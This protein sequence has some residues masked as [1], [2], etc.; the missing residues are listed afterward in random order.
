MT[1]RDTV[2]LSP[3]ASAASEF[4]ALA[5]MTDRRDTAIVLDVLARYE[6]TADWLAGVCNIDKGHLSR[7]LNGQ[8]TMP[9]AVTTA[10]YV[11][12]RDAKLRDFLLG[13]PDPES[14]ITA[15]GELAVA[16]VAHRHA[17]DEI[18]R[19][20]RG[21]LDDNGSVRILDDLI[22]QQAHAMHRLRDAAARVAA[23][24]LRR[25]ASATSTNKVP[26]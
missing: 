10:L 5:Q 4:E 8:Y 3:A 1:T 20:C 12:T 21:I 18:Y 15:H 7:V 25:V 13:G 17:S 16:L 6:L 24:R 22:T 26:A 23:I 2:Q 14:R 19:E 9:Q 11:E